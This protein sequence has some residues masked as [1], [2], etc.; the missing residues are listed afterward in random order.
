MPS[1]TDKPLD[2]LPVNGVFPL[3]L[4]PAFMSAL[5]KGKGA[6]ED[7]IGLKCTRL[8]PPSCSIYL[9]F[10]LSSCDLFILRTAIDS[11]DISQELS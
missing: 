10:L 2:G 9:I 3:T 11:E 5:G 1:T 8:S 4:S 6:K 7:V